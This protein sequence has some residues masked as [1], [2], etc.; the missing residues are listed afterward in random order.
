M[1]NSLYLAAA[2]AVGPMLAL[3]SPANAGLALFLNVSPGASPTLVCPGAGS[4]APCD[5][6]GAGNILT[7]NPAPLTLN[8]VIKSGE[9]ITATGV[10]GAPGLDTLSSSSLAVINTTGVTKTVHVIAS[11]TDYT[12]PVANVAL[13]GSGTFQAII[14]SIITYNWYA[15]PL[16]GQGADSSGSTPV[17]PHFLDDGDRHSPELRNQFRHSIQ[18][19]RSVLDD[20]RGDVHACAV[21]GVA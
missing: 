2:A 11:D 3:A 6:N 16:D 5:Y 4:P 17:A 10:P 13:S 20:G 9:L 15:D 8:G 19:D 18:R 12:F 1:R 7:L 21:W 14:G